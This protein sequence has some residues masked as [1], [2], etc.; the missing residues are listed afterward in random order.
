MTEGTL[1]P[2]DFPAFLMHSDA[3]TPVPTWK[4]VTRSTESVDPGF[5][6]HISRIVAGT[7]DEQVA[8]ETWDNWPGNYQRSIA[9]LVDKICHEGWLDS[10]GPI[11]GTPWDG[12]FFFWPNQGDRALAEVLN[13]KSAPGG[14]YTRCTYRAGLTA[15]LGRWG[16][17]A[18]KWGWVENDSPLAALHVGV[19]KDGSAEVHLDVFNP[20]C[21]SGAVP[22]DI[23]RW[24]LIGS[25]NHKLFSLHRRWEQSKY[26]AV[27][28][29]SAN[30]YHLMRGHVPLSF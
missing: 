3:D 27:A 22:S 26:G 15:R 23:T 24:P 5:V 7:N 30:F 9:L 12:G 6:A 13:S 28:R 1:L 11:R 17:K 18:W 16:H 21:V 20:L 19:F 4:Q 29:T 2:D 14:E 8:I 25:Y 10:V